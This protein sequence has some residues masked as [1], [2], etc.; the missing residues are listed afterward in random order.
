MPAVLPS[1]LQVVSREETFGSPEDR[2]FVRIIRTVLAWYLQYGG[3]GRRVTV[4]YVTDHFSNILVDQNDRDIVSPDEGLKSI[5]DVR[6][7]SV[8]VNHQEVWLSV[9]VQLSDPTEQEADASVLVPNDSHELPT[10]S[11][12]GHVCIVSSV[13]VRTVKFTQVEY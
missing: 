6:D 3:H 7:S 8:L 2:I 4:Q 9:L 10:S 1:L 13:I 12:Y 11:M 5:L